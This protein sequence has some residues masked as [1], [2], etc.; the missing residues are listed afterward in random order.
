MERYPRRVKELFIS[1]RCIGA[2][3]K[4]KLHIEDTRLV[5]N[6]HSGFPKVDVRTWGVFFQ[7]SSKLNGVSVAAT[8]FLSGIDDLDVCRSRPPVRAARMPYYYVSS[9]FINVMWNGLHLLSVG[10]VLHHAQGVAW[11]PA[12]TEKLA[13][14]DHQS[15][16]ICDEMGDT[17]VI[18]D[19]M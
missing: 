12:R 11:T 7:D 15:S 8:E 16:D 3:A 1:G 18:E 10:M 17:C 5:N 6:C 2:Y 4:K 19:S 14:S 13:K 9:S